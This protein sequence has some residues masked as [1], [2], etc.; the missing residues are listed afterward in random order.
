M[1]HRLGF[2]LERKLPVAADIVGLLFSVCPDAVLCSV[3]PIA[4]EPLQGM[5]FWARAHVCSKI[6]E[7]LPFLREGNASAA[8]VRVVSKIL[9][10]TAATHCIPDLPFAGFG[11]TVLQ[12][13]APPVVRH[14]APTR[15]RVSNSQ[16]T[17][18]SLYYS[19]TVAKAA[20]P[21][22][23]IAI[24]LA[25]VRQNSESAENLSNEVFETRRFFALRHC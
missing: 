10:L 9:I 5:T 13:P 23:A 20:P 16:I 6:C 1:S 17:A 7:V 19:A 14:R 11:T 25:S 3:V 12:G 21:D 22:I 8:V 18:N 15:R 2:T 24:P 4:V